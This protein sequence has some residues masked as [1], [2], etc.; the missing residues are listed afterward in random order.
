MKFHSPTLLQIY[1][2]SLSTWRP[3]S[4]GLLLDSVNVSANFVII[5]LV[6][7]FGQKIKLEGRP[8]EHFFHS[9][10]KGAATS[11]FS[12]EYVYNTYNYGQIPLGLLLLCPVHMIFLDF[13]CLPPYTM[14]GIKW[15]TFSQCT[16]FLL[17]FPQA[18]LNGK[19]G[20]AREPRVCDKNGVER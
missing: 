6:W 14:L 19:E 10:S 18:T 20:V 15:F 1:N 5:R 7:N 11:V 3:G 16:P 4:P 2:F 13:R 9:S 8:W 12:I 17:H